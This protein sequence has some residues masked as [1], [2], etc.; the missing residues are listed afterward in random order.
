M[1]LIPTGVPDGFTLSIAIGVR[2]GAD[3]A[4]GVSIEGIRGVDVQ[5][6]IIGVS[7]R[8]RGW[9]HALLLS[10]RLTRRAA[11]LCPRLKRLADNARR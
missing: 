9:P 6:T 1:Y 7:I 2:W 3:R 10:S 11:A 8:I 5:V 4:K